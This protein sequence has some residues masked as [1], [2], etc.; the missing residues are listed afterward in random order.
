MK[1]L[2]ELFGKKFNVTINTNDF[3]KAKYQIMG[4]MKFT[5]IQD[6]VLDQFRNIFHI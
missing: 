4:K 3:E 6:D 2:V 5:K 1:V